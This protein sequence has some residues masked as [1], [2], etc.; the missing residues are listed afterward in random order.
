[1]QETNNQPPK[2]P[3]QTPELTIHGDI[4]AITKGSLTGSSLDA[5]YPAGTHKDD[6]IWG[7]G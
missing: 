3:Y 5:T 1:M 2:K 7:S 6:P 4:G